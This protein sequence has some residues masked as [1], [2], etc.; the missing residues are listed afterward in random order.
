MNINEWDFADINGT[1]GDE[2]RMMVNDTANWTEVVIDRDDKIAMQWPAD[3]C[4]G[5][6]YKYFRDGGNYIK[7]ENEQDAIMFRLKF[8]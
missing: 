8:G 4:A 1:M 2:I 7:F 5:I 3:N 6:F